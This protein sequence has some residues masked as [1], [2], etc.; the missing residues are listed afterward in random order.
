MNYEGYEFLQVEPGDD[1]ILRITMNRPEKLNSA[2]EQGH[3]EQGRIWKDFDADPDMNV[4]LITG[5]GRAFAAG[6]DIEKGLGPL[7]VDMRDGGA[8][9]RNMVNCRKP[10]VSAINGVA[11]GGG[12][13]VALLADISIASE[14]AILIDGH[15]KIG[16]VAGDH[17]ALVWPLAMGMARAKYHLLMCDRIGGKEA[18]EL[19]MVSLCVPH[20]ELMDKAEEIAQKLAT[21]PQLALQG[22]KVALNGWYREHMSIFEH[23]LYAE[24]LSATLPDAV[25]GKAA[26]LRGEE[27]EFEQLDNAFLF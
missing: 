22:T 19:G 20:E 2:G 6:G 5:A 18:E 24:A 16:L 26:V 11:V 14:K 9:V 10:I 8:I 25:N 21:G 4:A 3:G 12:L 13:A 17:A 7:N 23:S 15:T 1:R 27:A